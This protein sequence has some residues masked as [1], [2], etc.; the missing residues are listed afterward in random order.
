[1]NKLHKLISDFLG[2]IK[3]CGFAIALKWLFQVLRHYSLILKDGNLKSADS[4]MGKGPFHVSLKRYNCRFMITGEDVFGG[5]REMY[6][7]DVYLR[8]GWLT[9][10]P[11]DTVVDLGANIGNFTNMAL[12][13][14]PTVRVI[15]VEPHIFSN[16]AFN[17][18]VGLNAGHLARVT[19]IRAFLG[20]DDIK[21]MALI[22]G[23][24][25]YAGAEWITEQQLIDRAN[26][27]SI[28]F[29]KC[30]I[31]GGEFGLLTTESKLLAMAKAL[32]VEVHAFAGDV[33]K[34]M[35][36]VVS[37]GF[38]IGPVQRDRDGTVTFL[39]KRKV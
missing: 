39:A 15:S 34:F 33:T 32:A 7:R 37:C 2:L 36:D 11:N 8:K 6:V 3:V 13:I 30:D 27:Q 21:S 10:K 9:I 23:D 1:M 4:A 20:L 28:D 38:I 16:R 35:A 31:E 25:N 29:L 5:I 18:S 12:A 24:E 17:K 19:L 22:A 14:D 26:I